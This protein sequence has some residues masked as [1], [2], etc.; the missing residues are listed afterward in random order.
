MEAFSQLYERLDR[1]RSTRAKVAAMVDYFQHASDADAAWAL[2]FLSG[3]RL[4]RLIGA[5]ELRRWI[6]QATGYP[7]WLFEDSYA[8]VGDLAETATL[9]LT[10][11][12]DRG[13]PLQLSL[14]ELVE[15]R[16]L[17]LR[18]QPEAERQAHVLTLWQRLP[19][20]QLFML[21]K[22][23]TG[24]LRVGVS[25]RLLLRAL[26]QRSGLEASTLAHR[27]MGQWQPGAAFFRGL[28]A[29]EDGRADLSRPYP[30]FLASPLEE[31]PASLGPAADWLVEWK[32]DGIRAQLVRRGGQT[33]IWSRGG[34]LMAG[35]FPEVEAA[36]AGL[37][38]GIVLDGELLAWDAG[39]P[40]DF[41]VLQQRIGRKRPGTR[42]LQ[43]APV[44]FMAYDLLER[45][46]QDW[47]QRPLTERRS[48]LLELLAAAPE[49]LH[50]ERVEAPDWASLA[51][52][53]E[54][55]RSRSTEGLMLK[56]WTSP[57]RTG[58]V[59]GDWW[60]W[61]TAPVTV[62]AV[63]IYAQAGHGRRANLYTDYTFAV[64]QDDTLVP[65]ARA[66]SGLTDEEIAELDR[67]IRRH[68]LERYGPVRSVQAI[69]VFE[70]AFEGVHASARHKSG[71]AV[72]FPR[73]RRWRRDL[74][75]ADADQ[76][77]VLTALL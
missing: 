39:G 34:E 58:R 62:D 17:P 35:R 10:H 52:A 60:K 53:R 45:A 21:N 67:W 15:A 9:L 47:R 26:S 63:L 6:Q 22:V 43:Q 73:I 56:R 16:L 13:A 11:Q 72:R 25:E 18:G 41:G 7:P 29:A 49:L 23:L 12:N 40:L 19:P 20:S 28:M 30:F 24:G 36:A 38:D 57:Y 65:V 54:T 48:A 75:P 4:K 3:R 44:A 5:S 61:K 66:C 2:Y 31:P 74:G 77:D 69:Q 33:F 42:S 59:R 68:T 32:W 55:A 71:V 1:T 51:A 70:L 76:L 14:A 37:A 8:H 64:W 27:L 50:S 46:G